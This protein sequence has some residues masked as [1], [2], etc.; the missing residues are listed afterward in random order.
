MMG[1]A[2]FLFI[3]D[4]QRMVLK[5]PIIDMERTGRNIEMLR[6]KNNMTVRDLQE[7]FGFETPQ[8][9]YKWQR[10]SALP[11]VDNLLYLAILFNVAIE[12]ILV[13]EDE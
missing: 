11:T 8:A 12:E 6:K 3:D 7:R 2:V 4:L 5:M 13:L 1:T 10:G 9:I